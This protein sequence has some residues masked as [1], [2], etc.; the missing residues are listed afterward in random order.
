VDM[1]VQ[2]I[3]VVADLNRHDPSNPGESEG[4]DGTGV[5]TTENESLSPD[6]QGWFGK[7]DQ[8][9]QQTVSWWEGDEGRIFACSPHQCT[10]Q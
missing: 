7:A 1:R 6:A 9:M 4:Q 8:L 10:V 5:G 3:N 2:D